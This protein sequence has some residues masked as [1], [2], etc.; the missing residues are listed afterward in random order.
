[1][2]STLDDLPQLRCLKRPLGPVTADAQAAPWPELSAIALRETATGEPP[3]QATWFK[4]AWNDQELRVLF[5]IED[6]HIVAAMTERDS[7]LYLEDVVELFL[8]PVGD[9]E[10]Y[11]EFEVNALN[12]VLDLVLRREET[13]YHKN[14]Q[15]QCEGLRTAAQRHPNG[16]CAEISIPFASLGAN[17]QGARW[18][19]NFY[20]I[21]HPEQAPLE[22][23]AWSPTRQRNFHLPERFGVL[24]FTE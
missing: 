16:W 21:D 8:D 9:L 1:M 19:A 3:K 10:T 2:S 15:W 6:T 4:T 18:R 7:L 5:W 17:P 14:F 11:F 23:S 22:L 13:E 24:E 12:T 20:R